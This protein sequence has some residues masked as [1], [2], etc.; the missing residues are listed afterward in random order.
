M[1]IWKDIVEKNIT[2]DYPYFKN[3]RSCGEKIDYKNGMGN[4]FECPECGYV[5]CYRCAQEKIV[6]V[7]E[8]I[9]LQNPALFK[10]GKKKYVYKCPDCKFV[11]GEEE[12]YF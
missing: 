1:G 3:C 8:P 5:L 4:N 11:V 2:G 12:E 10:S 6:D 9:V 7:A